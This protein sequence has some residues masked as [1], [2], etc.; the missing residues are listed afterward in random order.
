MLVDREPTPVTV[1]TQPRAAYIHVP[2]CA[3]RCGYCNFTL[4]ARRDDLIETYLAALA[5]ELQALGQPREV[6]TLFIGGGTP[7]HLEPAQLERL[8]MLVR[9][10]F[11]LAAGYEFSVEANPIDIT[12]ERVGVLKA[13]GVNRVSLGAQSFSPDKLRLLERD[14]TPEQIRTAIELLR[15]VVHSVSLDLIFAAPGETLPEWQA[16]VEQALALRPD[17]LSTYGLTFERGTTFY[18]RKLRHE[19]LAVDEETE[20]AMYEFALERLPA[21]GLA[22]YEVSNFARPGYECR[23]NEVYWAADEYF[24]AGPGAARYVAGTR[25]V[26]HRSVSTWIKRVLEGHSPVAE[27]ETLDAEDRARE[28]LAIGL[29]RVAGVDVARFAERFGFNVEAL[30]ARDLARYRDLGLL[31]IEHGA[32]RLTRRGLLLADTVCGSIVRQ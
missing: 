1:T 6:E 32:L 22:Q 17:H 28:A 27:E 23:H 10:W 26:N 8:L 4:V 19:L 13:H 2:F 24:A 12:S 31:A 29:R 7:T 15:P 20:A 21:A 11:P 14:H 25:Q 16:D 9:Q 18:G 30:M 3:H 5:C